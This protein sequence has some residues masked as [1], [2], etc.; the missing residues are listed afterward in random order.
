ML[1][2]T[3]GLPLLAFR[4]AYRDSYRSV[5]AIGADVNFHYFDREQAR[6]GCLKSNQFRKFL[7]NRFGNP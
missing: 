7:A 5:F 2:R 1:E 4:T 3:H 6:V